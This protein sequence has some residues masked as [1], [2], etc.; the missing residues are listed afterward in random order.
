[1]AE[2]PRREKMFC[3]KYLRDA[4]NAGACWEVG[5]VGWAILS[6]VVQIEDS[7]RYA[8]PPNFWLANFQN[9]IGVG[10]NAIRRA[11]D[12]CVSK[13]W[14]HCEPRTNRQPLVCWVTTPESLQNEGNGEGNES[15]QNEGNGEGSPFPIPPKRREWRGDSEGNGNSLPY[16]TP[17]PTPKEESVGRSEAHPSRA[18]GQKTDRPTDFLEDF[19]KWFGDVTLDD[20][21]ST[22]RLMQGL[23]AVAPAQ[24]DDRARWWI[25]SIALRARR[26]TNPPGLFCSLI[27]K[28]VAGTTKQL[29]NELPAAKRLLAEWKATQP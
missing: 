7:K 11:L 8:S 12:L 15:L 22:D 19:L 24:P 27:R 1:M 18:N 16:P 29:Q 14:L 5:A 21:Q 2:Y 10:E 4:M 25:L 17:T 9:R 13:G 26:G 6:I 28:G 23:T 20:I 3:I